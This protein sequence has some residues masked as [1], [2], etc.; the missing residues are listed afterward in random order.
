MKAKGPVL[1][2]MGGRAAATVPPPSWF[3][4]GRAISRIASFTRKERMANFF[5]SLKMVALAQIWF[6]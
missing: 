2:A 5:G 6:L 4:Q 3:N 1:T